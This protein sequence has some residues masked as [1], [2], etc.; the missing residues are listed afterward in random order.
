MMLCQFLLLPY[1]A[2]PNTA[3]SGSDPGNLAGSLGLKC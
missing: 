3:A 1:P 2:M